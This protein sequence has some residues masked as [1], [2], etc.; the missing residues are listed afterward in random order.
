M[1]EILKQIALECAQIADPDGIEKYLHSI[2]TPAEVSGGSMPDNR[3]D[4]AVNRS[5]SGLRCNEQVMVLLP[6]VNVEAPNARS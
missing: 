4:I 6:N 1:N 2:L 5:P 3:I